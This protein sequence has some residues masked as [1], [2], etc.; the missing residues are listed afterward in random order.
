MKKNILLLLINFIFASYFTT[1]HAGLCAG[2]FANPITDIC[3]NCIFPLTIGALPVLTAGQEDNGD[4]PPSP[5]C[6]CATP[7]IPI[8]LT[9]GYWEPARRLDVTRTP[10]CMVSLGM[11][12][13]LPFPAP[14]GEVRLH[15][16]ETKHSFW[17]AHWYVDPILY[18]LEAMAEHP[19]LE[20]GN[21]DLSYMTEIDPLWN[22][23]ELTALL[24]PE[25]YLFGNPIAQLACVGDCIMATATFGSN[26]LFWCAGCNGSIYPLNGRVA[27]HVSEVQASSLVAQRF[28]AKMHR[29]MLT[30]G[31]SGEQGLCGVYPQPVMRKDQYKY[32]MLYP[33]SQSASLNKCCQP[34]GRTTAIWGAGRSFPIKGEDFSYE[35]FRKKNC[36][37]GPILAP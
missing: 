29:Q 2:K 10:Y 1:A 24:N 22:N 25:T 18:W 35:L 26:L 21:F 7:F 8:G 20:T 37:L 32:S 31:T 11:Q 9:F 28:T 13:P 17:Q 15:S 36:C 23:D 5:I 12:I 16:D 19:C 34:F 3:W 27:A 33:V 30:W 4:N 6:A 14:E